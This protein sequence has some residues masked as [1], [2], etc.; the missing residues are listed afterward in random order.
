MLISRRYPGHQLPYKLIEELHEQC[1]ACQKLRTRHPHI[2]IEPIRRSLAVYEHFH[3]ISIDGMPISPTDDDG[4]CHVNIINNWATGRI[5]LQA[6]ADKSAETAVEALYS[7]RML[8]GHIARLVSDPGSDYTSDIVRIYNRFTGVDHQITDVDR[9]QANGTERKVQ[10]VKRFLRQL[11]VTPALQRSW[12]KPRTLH[13]AAC[14]VNENPDESTGISCNDLHFGR[15]DAASMRSL[16]PEDGVPEGFGRHA[17]LDALHTELKAVR[18]IWATRKRILT[19]RHLSTNPDPSKQNKF[20]PGDFVFFTRRARPS[21]FSA[22]NRG[23]YEVIEHI[24]NRVRVRDLVTSKE[25]T[26]Q[27]DRLYLFFGTEVAARAQACL[28]DGQFVVE[29]ILAYRGQPLQR[30]SCEFLVR[31]EDGETI[32][33][34]W[35]PDLQTNAAFVAYC[36]S[37]AELTPFLFDTIADAK[38]AMAAQN[39]EAMPFSLPGTTIYV[40][41]RYDS[42]TWYTDLPFEQNH[43]HRPYYVPM[44]FGEFYGK[45][46]RTIRVL[47][48]VVHPGFEYRFSHTD[49]LHWGRYRTIDAIPNPHTILTRAMVSANPVFTRSPTTT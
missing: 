21:T 48:T 31:Y 34:L 29:D 38:L 28:D 26:F 30:L 47:D 17:Y 3:T 35:S 20:A 4:N 1:A 11:A 9:P 41:L 24:H 18:E 22:L 13:H 10:E 39:K 27:V 33:I 25:S 42:Q 16:V 43:L 36:T 15:D 49:L 44:T 45:T 37:H 14:L 19:A 7:Y 23:P 2:S 32:W 5:F 46:R 12:S 40:A 8:Y 6:A